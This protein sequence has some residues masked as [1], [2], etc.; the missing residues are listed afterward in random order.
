MIKQAVV[1]TLLSLAALGAH[2]EVVNIDNA[3]LARLVASGVAIIDIRTA[4]EWKETGIIAGSRLLT[5]FDEKGRSDAPAWLEKAK[6][7]AKPEQPVILICRSGN[8][9]R[10]ATQFLSQQAGY[11]TVYNVSGGLNAWAREGRA[12]VPASSAVAVC[13]AGARC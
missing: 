1:T 4:G 8:R 3:E 11:K 6:L 7:V 10:A 2:A 12:V 9:T 5:F 13:A